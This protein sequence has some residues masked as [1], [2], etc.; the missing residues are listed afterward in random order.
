MSNVYRD[1]I[2][3]IINVHSIMIALGN[4]DRRTFATLV[5]YEWNNRKTTNGSMFTIQ[6]SDAYG[7][8]FNASHGSAGVNANCNLYAI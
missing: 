8:L 1:T 6:C 5:F 4:N 2:D 7:P 3:V